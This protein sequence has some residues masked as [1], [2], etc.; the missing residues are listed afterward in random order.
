M[1]GRLIEIH[2]NARRR[3]IHLTL[4][5]VQAPSGERQETDKGYHPATCRSRLAYNHYGAGDRVGLYHQPAFK[6]EWVGAAGPVVAVI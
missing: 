2:I 1:E 4:A 3:E 6:K 5:V